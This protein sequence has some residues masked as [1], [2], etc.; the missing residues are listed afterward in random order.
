MMQQRNPTET[1]NINITKSNVHIVYTGNANRVE[2]TVAVS[3]PRSDIDEYDISDNDE[4]DTTS[5]IPEDDDPLAI[6]TIDDQDL[7]EVLT[8]ISTVMTRLVTKKFILS[9][10]ARNSRGVNTEKKIFDDQIIGS[11]GHFIA[12]QTYASFIDQRLYRTEENG[13]NVFKRENDDRRE[14]SSPL[15]QLYKSKRSLYSP[16]KLQAFKEMVG[17]D[18]RTPESNFL[19]MCNNLFFD[20]DQRSNLVKYER[21]TRYSFSTDTLRKFDYIFDAIETYSDSVRDETYFGLQERNHRELY[22]F[23]RVML[24]MRNDDHGKLIFEADTFN[25]SSFNPFLS[26]GYCAAMASLIAWISWIPAEATSYVLLSSTRICRDERFGYFAT[27]YGWIAS[28][29]ALTIGAI[30]AATFAVGSMATTG[31]ISCAMGVADPEN[32]ADSIKYVALFDSVGVILRKVY[33]YWKPAVESVEIRNKNNNKVA[34]VATMPSNVFMDMATKI[35]K[36]IC[37]WFPSTS[38]KPDVAVMDSTGNIDEQVIENDIAS[39]YQRT[40]NDNP[41]EVYKDVPTKSIIYS[42]IEEGDGTIKLLMRTAADEARDGGDGN[43]SVDAAVRFFKYKIIDPYLKYNYFNK[44]IDANSARIVEKNVFKLLESLQQNHNRRSNAGFIRDDKQYFLEGRFVSDTAMAAKRHNLGQCVTSATELAMHAPNP[45]NE[46]I[47]SIYDCIVDLDCLPIPID[48]DDIVSLVDPFIN[49]VKGCVFLDS[50]G[51]SIE[52]QSSFITRN[53]EQSY[54]YEYYIGNHM[55]IGL[56]LFAVNKRIRFSLS[57]KPIRTDNLLGEMETVLRLLSSLTFTNGEHLTN[58]LTKTMD[59]ACRIVRE[60]A[61]N[62]TDSVMIGAAFAN[63][64]SHLLSYNEATSPILSS[65]SPHLQMILKLFVNKYARCL[66]MEEFETNATRRILLEVVDLLQ[67]A[68]RNI[69]DTP[70]MNSYKTKISN[71]TPQDVS[72]VWNENSWEQSQLGQRIVKYINNDPFTM[73]M[74]KKI[75][76][77]ISWDLKNQTSASNR[78]DKASLAD[79]DKQL[80]DSMENKNAMIESYIHRTHMD[81][82]KNILKV[83]FDL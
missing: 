49:D 48:Y 26:H 31:D 43:P 69:N 60:C 16:M 1:S 65:R 51:I 80:F 5:D 54:N 62:T 12:V 41:W 72:S 25:S 52:K 42:H 56:L 46:L 55:K 40:M 28:N 32:L 9:L 20:S 6:T 73:E 50:D 79:V 34:T 8:R 68:V 77:I 53:V 14:I 33:Y 7:L 70:S 29:Y 57:E 63:K 76:P 35:T 58:K 27:G 13:Y 45:A 24:G 11:L 22:E 74:S 82:G 81:F 83:N 4:M 67:T 61:F 2:N 59:V 18:G 10:T 19:L 36:R 37:Y 21:E 39:Y 64:V 47:S 66:K 3:T 44:L 30:L 38:V 75:R 15:H 23:I 78:F 71:L 17:M